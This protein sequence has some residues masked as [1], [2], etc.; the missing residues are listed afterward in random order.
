MTRCS[1]LLKMTI[2][3]HFGEAI[4]SKAKLSKMAD[5]LDEIVVVN[6]G[7]GEMPLVRGYG[8]ITC[9]NFNGV[10]IASHLGMCL[11]GL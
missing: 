10:K 1:K 3:K 9:A 2:F 8:Q 4:Y 6:R 5:F 11:H 7:E